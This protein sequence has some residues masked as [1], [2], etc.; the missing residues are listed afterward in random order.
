M[1]RHFLWQN[2]GQATSIIMSPVHDS[3]D[4]HRIFISSHEIWEFSCISL[5]YESFLLFRNSRAFFYLHLQETGLAEGVLINLIPGQRLDFYTGKIDLFIRCEEPGCF[6]NSL[7]PFIFSNV[8]GPVLP[9]AR[10]DHRICGQ[11]I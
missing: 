4:F 5:S 11:I 3:A 1:D 7:R 8:I 10:I 9:P 2:N 6:R